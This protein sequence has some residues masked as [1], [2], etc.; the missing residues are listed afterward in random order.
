MTP[1]TIS[2]LTNPHPKSHIVYPYGDEKHVAEA[3]GIFAAAGLSSNESVVLIAT[4]EK[5][6]AIEQRLREEAFDVEEL[7]REGR[8]TSLNADMLLAKLLA[9]E[10][11]DLASFQAVVGPIIVAA[12]AKAPSGRV[13]LYGEMVNLLCGK[14][15]LEG[16]AHLED[17]WN[18]TIE[19]YSV[20]LLCSYSNDLLLPHE[21]TGLP[22]RLLELH[23][24]I[25]A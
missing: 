20:P 5:Q 13:R 8:L 16:A 7:Q 15:D 1:K 4:A 9:C 6:H 25:A 17:L 18:Q 22:Q 10:S 3:V 23:S 11:P 19:L 21:S 14:S 2:I 12:K 24:D